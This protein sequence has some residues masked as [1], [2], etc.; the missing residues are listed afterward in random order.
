M[1]EKKGASPSVVRAMRYIG[2]R[3]MRFVR[4]DI[5]RLR[6]QEVPAVLRL[7]ANIIKV[8]YRSVLSF[9]DRDL[10]GKAAS[11]TYSTVLSI[12]PMLAVIV[13]VAKGFG[14]QT[15]V[16]DALS[17]ALPGQR[18]QLDQ[19]FMYVE[20]YLSQVQGGL[21]IGLGLAIL[22]Y[23]VLMLMGSIED[24]FNDI[25]QAPHARPW[26]RRLFDYLGLFLLLPLLLTVS[27]MITLT[28]STIRS[29]Y[30]EEVVVFRS[31]LDGVL[32]LVPFV[33]SV[34]IFVGL[35]M[36]LPNV[37]VRFVP[38][39]ISGVIAGIAYQVFQGLYI[40]GVIWI[41]RYNAI[42]G[43]FAAFPLLLL[44][45]QLSWTITLFGAQLAY[46]IQNVRSFS[47]GEASARVSRRYSDFVGLLV[48][49]RIIVRF[50]DPNASPYDAEALSQECHI[51]LRMTG[52]VLAR[53]ERVGLITAVQHSEESGVSYY[54]PAVDPQVLTV[55]YVVTRL[56]RYGT[57][58][59]RIDRYGKYQRQWEA[60]LA[61]R[62]ALVSTLVRDL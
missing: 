53:L 34:G 55:D 51:P 10:S 3:M 27:S 60:V 36:Y 24:T 16:R 18:V 38:A 25:W 61:S 54:Q 33:V 14:L 8:V 49:N 43:S 23:T 2:L 29:S 9:I 50:G 62:S 11:L 52:E 26:R 20:N 15:V 19:V 30:L 22:L 12:V 45:L 46:S 17:E 42:Y 59:F 44:W 6:P 31:L 7:P 1:S 47:F 48:L 41:S 13:G 35:Y 56:D 21:F 4:I 40:N 32:G 39:L 37:R 28:L 57:E 5:W 58:D